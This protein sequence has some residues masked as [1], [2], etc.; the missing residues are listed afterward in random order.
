MRIDESDIVTILRGY[1]SSAE[2]IHFPSY[3]HAIP[4]TAEVCGIYYEPQMAAWMI[5]LEDES[6]PLTS[7]GELLMRIDARAEIIKLKRE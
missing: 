2:Y 7:P 3:R 1:S 5:V 4:A 6:F